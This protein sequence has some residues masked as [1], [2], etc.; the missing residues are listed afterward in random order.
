MTENIRLVSPGQY[1]W[2]ISI[3]SYQLSEVQQYVL[4][5]K[6]AT[7]PSI[8]DPGTANFSSLG[9]QVLPWST[10]LFTP[11]QTPIRPRR[12]ST[13]NT[14]Q[15]VGL[16]IGLA[17]AVLILLEI[18]YWY[19]LHKRTN[20]NLSDSGHVN[21]PEVKPEVPHELLDQRK[22]RS[23]LSDQHGRPGELDG[24]PLSNITNSS[25]IE[26]IELAT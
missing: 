7:L 2:T 21:V 15:Q 1:N 4:Q 23:E 9:F 19:M 3:P 17:F 12:L 10:P 11:T 6:P 8:Y 18:V 13:L 24:Y 25:V 22:D 16:V 20:R 14:S 26:P 5:L